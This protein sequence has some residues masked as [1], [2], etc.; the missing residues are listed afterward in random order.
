MSFTNTEYKTLFNLLQGQEPLTIDE[1]NTLYTDN[2]LVM[3][4][5]FSNFIIA[6][7]KRGILLQTFEDGTAFTD[8]PVYLY[9]NNPDLIKHNIANRALFSGRCL[10]Q[11]IFTGSSVM[12]SSNRYPCTGVQGQVLGTTL[13]TGFGAQPKNRAA[14]LREIRARQATNCCNPDNCCTNGLSNDNTN[15]TL[16]EF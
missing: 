5:N 9:A 7:R 14:R 16:G 3:P 15:H 2:G 8:N 13:V 1:I 12:S 10:D 11:F 4:I 6:A